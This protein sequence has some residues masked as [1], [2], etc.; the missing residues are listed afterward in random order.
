MDGTNFQLVDEAGK[1]R[2]AQFA[3]RRLVNDNLIAQIQEPQLL[4]YDL[5]R[6]Q[7]KRDLVAGILGGKR[8]AGVGQ[9]E[10]GVR[11]LTSS[12]PVDTLNGFNALLQQLSTAR[13]GV[14]GGGRADAILAAGVGSLANGFFGGA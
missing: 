8:M 4:Q 6:A 5:D 9:A 14:I 11:Q 10:Q 7:S 3:L 1:N 2:E 13:S 12:N